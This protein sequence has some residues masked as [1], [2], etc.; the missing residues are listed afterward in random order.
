MKCGCGDPVRYEHIVDG[1]RLWSCNKYQICLPYNDLRELMQKYCQLQGMYK[2][3]LERIYKTDAKD[4]Q[5]R[6]WAKE[7]LEKWK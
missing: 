3:T 7:T 1:K 6:T 5:Y 2:A 4:Y